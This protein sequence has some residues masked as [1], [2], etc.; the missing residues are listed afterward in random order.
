MKRRWKRGL[1]P[2][3]DRLPE[4]IDTQIGD[5]GV[6]LSVGERQRVQLA[7]VLV[8][9]PRVLVLDEA[10]A[11][12]DYATEQQLRSLLFERPSCPTTLVIAHRYS[13]VQAADHV[14]VIDGGRVVAEGT[15]QSVRRSNEWF[16][17]FAAAAV[18]PE[19]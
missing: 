12:L 9:Q 16:A 14:V 3:L 19:A 15:P 17:R 18:E 6:G 11:N 7:R 4:G 1:A 8:S 2:L 13:M 5:G 10:T